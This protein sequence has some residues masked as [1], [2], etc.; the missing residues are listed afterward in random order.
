MRRTS[1]VLVALIASLLVGSTA[2]TR[3]IDG[4]ARP[5]P[6]R[7][8]VEIVGDGYG[9]KIGFPDAPVQL[10][11]YT[12]PQC[13][14][15]ADLQ[16]DFGDQLR[17][18]L[19]TGQL[20]ITYRPMTFLDS[21]TNLHSER[22]ANAMFAAA[23]PAGAEDAGTVDAIAFQRFVEEAWKHYRDGADHP[24]DGELGQLARDAGIPDGQ[25]AAID[26]G[27]P[28]VDVK[29]LEDTNFGLLYFAN[30]A[31]V[32]TPTVLDLTSG[33]L[34]DVYDDDWLAKVMAS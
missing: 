20:A 25:V 17:G 26:A 11:I 9:I 33:E 4:A 14:H 23:A 28:A 2:C 27:D 13:N 16:A 15:C 22:V 18:Y 3:A 24:S 31:D 10:E 34:L 8:P 19:G 5:D 29:E 30:P 12:E 21:G 6:G 32:G 7:P 1:V